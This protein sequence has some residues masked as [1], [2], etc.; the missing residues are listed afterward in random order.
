MTKH[1]P[2][3]WKVVY[4]QIL[5][6]YIKTQKKD[7]LIADILIPSNAGTMHTDRWKNQAKANAHLIAA[8]PDLLKTLIFALDAL[9]KGDIGMMPPVVARMAIAIEKA[10][11]DTK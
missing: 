11:G 2:G 8:A 4:D 6:T 7:K 1:T 5:F 9:E 3:P 10:K